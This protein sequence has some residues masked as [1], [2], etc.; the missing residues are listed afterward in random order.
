DGVVPYPATFH[1][2]TD[3][4]KALLILVRDAFR[5]TIRSDYIGELASDV[6]LTGTETNPVLPIAAPGTTV[7]IADGQ[8]IVV[9]DDRSA[10]AYPVVVDNDGL[11]V[12]EGVLE[13]P[14]AEGSIVNAP[15]GAAVKLHLGQMQSDILQ[16][17]DEILLRATN[18]RVIET[19]IQAGLP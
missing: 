6:I 10:G 15:E 7:G 11:R 5:V 16:N 4:L 17:A 1:A 18:E 14:I 8:T 13:I 3:Q 2:R 9:I 12:A 19:I